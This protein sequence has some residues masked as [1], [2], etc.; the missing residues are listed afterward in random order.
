MWGAGPVFLLPT[1][2]DDL[3]GAEKWGVGPTA[4]ALKQEG[5]WTFGALANHIW[6]V[7]GDSNRVD[8]SNT[9][10]QPFMSYTTKTAMT[11]SQHRIHL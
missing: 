9:F 10:L 6:S 8:I 2:T 11:F 4:V 3:L 5:P 1:A 7:A